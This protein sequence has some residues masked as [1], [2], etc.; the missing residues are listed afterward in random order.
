MS[1][2][3]PL[4][5]LLNTMD[6]TSVQE[7]KLGPLDGCLAVDCLNMYLM[8]IFT[9]VESILNM[10]MHLIMLR[11]TGRSQSISFLGISP[12]VYWRLYHLLHMAAFH[13]M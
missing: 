11:G 13:T 1:I 5:G 4:F 9:L 10:I 12:L 3:E 2:A 7:V 8:F 6:D